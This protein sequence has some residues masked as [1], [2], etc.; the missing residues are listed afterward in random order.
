V[1][2]RHAREGTAQ[3]SKQSFHSSPYSRRPDHK[4]VLAVLEKAAQTDSDLLIAANVNKQDP[5]DFAL[6][7]KCCFLWVV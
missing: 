7:L 1:S 2:Q 3:F 4:K 5:S 6:A